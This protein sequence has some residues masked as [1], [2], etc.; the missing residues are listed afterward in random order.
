MGEND[1]MTRAITLALLVLLSLAL[2]SCA[3][4]PDP[5]T[6]PAYDVTRS[7]R[8]TR[9]ANQQY[10]E[11]NYTRALELARRAIEL[12]P[13]SPAAWNALGLASM[14]LALHVQAAEAFQRAGE[15]SPTDHRPFDNLGCLYLRVGWGEPALRAYGVALERSPDSLESLRGAAEAARRLNREDHQTLER[16]TRL[17]IVETDPAYRKEYQL[18]RLRIEQQLQEQARGN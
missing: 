4:A 15:L 5:L 11:G 10:R 1:P 17:L 18:R 3:A 13:E 7:N 6:P 14:E 9:Q 8:L 16:L 12:Y 2:A